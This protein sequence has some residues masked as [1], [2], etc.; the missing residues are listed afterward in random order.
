MARAELQQ[1]KDDPFATR[2][3]KIKELRKQ[4][5]PKLGQIAVNRYD[6]ID[7]LIE[8]FDE[9]G[10]ALAE[11]RAALARSNSSALQSLSEVTAARDRIAEELRQASDKIHGLEIENATMAAKVEKAGGVREQMMVAYRPWMIHLGENLPAPTGQ[12]EEGK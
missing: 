7:A 5:D 3:A 1:A 4:R 10:A 8:A 11:T 2:E 9:T 12:N 6:F